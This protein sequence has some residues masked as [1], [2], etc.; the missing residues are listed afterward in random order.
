M[1]DDDQEQ[2]GRFRSHSSHWGAF[3]ARQDG[4]GGIEVKPHELDPDPFPLIQNFTDAVGHRSR[5]D[6]P[7]VRRGW[8]DGS[9]REGDSRRGRDEYIPM[10]WDAIEELLAAEISRVY[11]TYGPTA[12]FGGSYGWSSAGRFHHAQSQVHR[13]LNQLGG[14]TRSVNTYSLGAGEVIVPHVTGPD[15]GYPLSTASTWTDLIGNCELM[16]C[17]GGLPTKNVAVNA[18]GLVKHRAKLSIKELAA[19]GC[20][21]VNI[22][23]LGYDLPDVQVEKWIAPRPVSDVALMLALC[24]ELV[25][26]GRADLEFLES[27]TTGH[28]EF[29]DYVLGHV[30]GQPKDAA[31]AA[32]LC[33]IEEDDI[34]WLATRMHESKTL[35]T[36]TPSLQRAEH[37][38]QPIWAAIALS[39]V[40]GSIGKPGEGFSVGFGA[41]GNVG[42]GHM[43]LKFPSFPQGRNNAGSYIPVARIS[44]LLLHPGEPFEYN[45]QDLTYP[46]IRLVYWA[47]GNPFHHHQDLFRL[48][49][50]FQRPDTIVVHEMYWT[51]TARH[52]DFVLP[53]TTTLERID[54]GAAHNDDHLIAM[55]RVREPYGLARDDYETFAALSKRLGTWNEF[56][57]GRSAEEWVRFLYEDWREMLA[58]RGHDVPS[59]DEFWELG[60]VDLP[61]DPEPHSWLDYFRNDPLGNR[62]STPSGKIELY[63][64]TIASFD[65]EDCRG[66]PSW[67]EPEEWLGGPLA[68]TYPFQLIANQPATRLH[69]QLDMGKHS[70]QAKSQGREVLTMHAQD[71]DD[72]GLAEGDAVRVHSTRGAFLAILTLT[73][74][75]RRH[76]VQVPTGAWFDPIYEQRLCVHGNPN[77][78]TLDRGTS[79]LAQG[80]IGQTCL[81]AVEKWDAELPP[82][83]CYE[84]PV[85]RHASEHMDA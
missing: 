53:A 16:V 13:F 58:G 1:S 10:E 18:G 60:T 51:G 63:S 11:L 75:I 20:S 25:T 76:V 5:I 6:R 9:P 14:Y 80:S 72:L 78:V 26:S 17:F 79:R 66:Y 40:L 2:E 69:S 52:A 33:E 15:S 83:T 59:F 7:Y 70:A 29:L 38:E 23:P 64:A 30:D 77:S 41:M 21:F 74:D 4:S 19:S 12:V 54:F 31:W 32:A 65:Y 8:L 46:D 43:K 81:V 48:S 22:S 56:T 35:I 44:D 49:E 73:T 62:L 71:A 27:Y 47:G 57:E 82:I 28:Q 68:A 36:I 61:L 55:E 3:R 34:R 45:G 85:A 37:G 84:P 24:H 67:F 50:A 42:N 39:S